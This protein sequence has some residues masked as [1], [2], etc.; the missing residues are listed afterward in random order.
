[1]KT[2]CEAPLGATAVGDGIGEGVGPSRAEVVLHV[3]ERAV[4]V[5]VHGAVLGWRLEV[6]VDDV[7]LDLVVVVSTTPGTGTSSLL[8]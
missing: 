3:H 5:Q 4:A 7:A 8:V 1:M 2:G 6:G